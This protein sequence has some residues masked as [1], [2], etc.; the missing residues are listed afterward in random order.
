MPRGSHTG[1][2]KHQTMLPLRSH[3]FTL[4]E[5][6]A[7]LATSV[8]QLVPAIPVIHYGTTTSK[9]EKELYIENKKKIEEKAG[10]GMSGKRR[11]SC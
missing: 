1:Q 2:E 9:L 11:S 10:P 3:D 8:Y 6:V 4:S 7:Y 5:A